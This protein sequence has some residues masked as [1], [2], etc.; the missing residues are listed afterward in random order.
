VCVCVCVSCLFIWFCVLALCGECGRETLK[1]VL[2]RA[3]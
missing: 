1:A 3:W 2:G